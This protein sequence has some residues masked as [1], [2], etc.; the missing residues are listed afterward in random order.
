VIRSTAAR[1]DGDDT[2]TDTD[3]ARSAGADAILATTLLVVTLALGVAGGARP[4]PIPLV[5]GVVATILA[6]LLA[7]RF[8]DRVRAAW[9]RQFVRVVA[10]LLSLAAVTGGILI[11]ASIAV[12]AAVGALGT[13]LCLFYTV[14]VGLL[15]PP[16]QWFS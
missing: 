1:L 3:R 11:D 15:P 16:D 5:A 6:E 4:A 10:I 8:A 9:E 7:G 13:Y 14:T 2:V 12:S